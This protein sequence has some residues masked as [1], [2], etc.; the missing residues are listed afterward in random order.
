MAWLLIVIAGVL[1]AVWAIAL[2]ESD[3][4][5][6]LAPTLI[7]LAAGGISIVLLAFALRDLPVGTGYAVWTGI[8]AVGAAIAGVII[9]GESATV[10]RLLAIALIATGIVWLALQENA[11][12]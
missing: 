1:E 12:A 3:G 9:L 7:F 10:P 8:G 2:K 5:S 11:T 4:F 6:K